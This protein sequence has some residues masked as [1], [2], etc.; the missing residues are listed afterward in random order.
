RAHLDSVRAT[1][2]E[3]SRRNTQP[4]SGVTS[5]QAAEPSLLVAARQGKNFRRR[6]KSG[7]LKLLREGE[8]ALGAGP[9]GWP[10]SGDQHLLVLLVFG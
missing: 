3:L 5:R 2:A 7:A 9:R 8:S 1:K 4:R 6:G 10:H